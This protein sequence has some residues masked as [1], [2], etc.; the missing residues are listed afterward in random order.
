MCIIHFSSGADSFTL[1][2]HGRT[3]PNAKN[4]WDANWLHCTAE[5]LVGAFRGILEWQLRNEDLARFM[6]ALEGLA[7][8]MGEAVLDT[9]DG[10]LDVRIIRDEQGHIE[11]RCQLVDNPAGGN[12][13]EFRLLLDQTVLP[14]LTGQLREVLERFPVVGQD[15]A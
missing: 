9:G 4:Y 6:H 8:R 1:R 13:L 10:W 5:V 14:A 7:G 15:G 2:I 3:N 11:A 12:S